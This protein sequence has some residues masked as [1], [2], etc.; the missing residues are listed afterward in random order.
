MIS[1][2]VGSEVIRAPVAPEILKYH[3]LTGG[4]EEEED[5]T[6]PSSFLIHLFFSTVLLPLP[7]L[8]TVSHLTSGLQEEETHHQKRKIQG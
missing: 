2:R 6:V 7:L 4:S 8:S 1:F 5:A 3:H